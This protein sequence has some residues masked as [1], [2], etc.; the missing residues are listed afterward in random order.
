MT[1][2]PSADADGAP[3]DA[4]IT[5]VDGADPEFVRIH[6]DASA[7]VTPGL[8]YL[9]DAP[10][11]HRDSGEFCFWCAASARMRHGYARSIS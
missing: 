8:G 10:G 3:I 6:A 5:W 9:P 11:R 4:V 1:R 2:E 7:K